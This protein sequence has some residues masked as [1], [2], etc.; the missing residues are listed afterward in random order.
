MQE[1]QT[2]PQLGKPL[3]DLNLIQHSLIF[4]SPIAPRPSGGSGIWG[5][6][7]VSEGRR[8]GFGGENE[9]R[10]GF[11]ERFGHFED[12]GVTESRE[13]GGLWV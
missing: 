5:G 9:G 8:Y 12:A 10:A 1:L 6:D 3:L 13:G 2:L 7:G 11:F 4:L